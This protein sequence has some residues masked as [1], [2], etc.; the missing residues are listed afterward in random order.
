[1]KRLIYFQGAENKCVKVA[2]IHESQALHYE[3]LGTVINGLGEF[4]LWLDNF[5]GRE[6]SSSM[7]PILKYGLDEQLTRCEFGVIGIIIWGFEMKLLLT[8]L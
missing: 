4:S 8:L 7:S 2:C 3:I 5:V 6:A 1:M